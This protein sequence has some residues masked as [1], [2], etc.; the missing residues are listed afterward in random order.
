M[1]MLINYCIVP[2]KKSIREGPIN[3]LNSINP[4]VH[5]SGWCSDVCVCV[6]VECVCVSARVCVE[7]VCVASSGSR[8]YSF[9]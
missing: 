6:F 5:W 8:Q 4:S 1:N 2:I 3:V 7:C 9:N